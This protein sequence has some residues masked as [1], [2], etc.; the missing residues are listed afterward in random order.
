LVAS[1][2]SAVCSRIGAPP[3]CGI[4]GSSP[5]SPYDVTANR[6]AAAAPWWH[7]RFCVWHYRVPPDDDDLADAEVAIAFAQVA[8]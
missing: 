3:L 4:G 1:Q 7:C 8:R 6:N 2:Q 5:G